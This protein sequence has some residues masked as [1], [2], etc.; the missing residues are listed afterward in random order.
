MFFFSK[1][2]IATALLN[3]RKYYCQ[4]L[5]AADNRI[6]AL[7]NPIEK[8]LKNFVK[9]AKWNDINFYAVKDSIAK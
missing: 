5:P 1:A 3:L 4:F 2:P 8:D 7:R 6:A 9:I